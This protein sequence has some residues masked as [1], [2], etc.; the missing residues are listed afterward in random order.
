MANQ[1][2][3]GASF[4]LQF[5]AQGQRVRIDAIGMDTVP[6]THLDVYKRQESEW[7]KKVRS[8]YPEPVIVIG[9]NQDQEH[10]LDRIGMSL[11]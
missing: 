2:F 3:Q 8:Q 11:N 4:F 7:P 9:G 10:G 1:L 5:D 6:Y